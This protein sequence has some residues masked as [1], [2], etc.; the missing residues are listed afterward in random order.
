MKKIF[1]ILCIAV[2]TINVSFADDKPAILVLGQSFNDQQ[3]SETIANKLTRKLVDSG[4][5]NVYQKE[6]LFAAQKKAGF[7]SILEGGNYNYSQI[8]EL[9]DLRAIVICKVDRKE[10]EVV[11]RKSGDSNLGYGWMYG[12]FFP[13]LLLMNGSSDKA[14]T[15]KVSS[16]QISLT[17]IETAKQKIIAQENLTDPGNIEQSIQEIYL[18]ILRNCRVK[19]QVLDQEDNLIYIDLGKKSGVANGDILELFH[20]EPLLDEKVKYG[21]LEVVETAND[22]AVCR[23]IT[24]QT[25]D[26][27]RNGD[28]VEVLP[29]ETMPLLERARRL[30]KEKTRPLGM[31]D[32]F[33]GEAVGPESIKYNA[34]GLGQITETAMSLNWSAQYSSANISMP[35][36]GLSYNVKDIYN[37]YVENPACPSDFSIV[38]PTERGGLGLNLNVGNLRI[39]NSFFQYDNGG[40]NLSLY[41]G[42]AVLPKILFGMGVTFSDRWVGLHNNGG[43]CEFRGG[44]IGGQVGILTRPTESL[45]LGARLEIPATING[46]LA[47]SANPTEQDF[48]FHDPENLG[49]GLSYKPLDRLVVNI[50]LLNYYASSIYD[51]KYGT[52]YMLTDNISLRLGTGGRFIR[53]PNLADDPNYPNGYNFRTNLYSAGV[54]LAFGS[55]TFDLAGEYEVLRE[56]NVVVYPDFA[57]GSQSRTLLTGYKDARIKFSTGVKF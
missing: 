18:T 38:V 22:S 27:V 12:F 24:T 51:V 3:V 28:L 56:G 19:G 49:L 5:F 34:A 48:S 6:E 42:A 57:A 9:L 13:P 20:T 21:E 25:F 53:L 52:E 17:A 50:D 7:P 36:A 4:R 40:I 1:L 31:G 46:R 29:M 23:I 2:V 39:N 37:S 47:N 44:G 8:A 16:Y 11:K 32:A 55:L 15:V 35:N 26:P 45:G 41:A 54:G 14:Y 43:S 30:P 33:I 10:K